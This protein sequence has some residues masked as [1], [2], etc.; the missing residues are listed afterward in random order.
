MT[1]VNKAFILYV[2]TNIFLLIC[3]FKNLY[4]YNLLG[5]MKT[6]DIFVLKSNSRDVKFW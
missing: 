4:R 1:H 6:W 2:S 3:D 5:G